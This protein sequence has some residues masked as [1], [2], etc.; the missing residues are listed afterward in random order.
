MPLPVR[1]GEFTVIVVA[2]VL[3]F[4]LHKKYQN[5]LKKAR[6]TSDISM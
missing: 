3:P 2:L 6:K 5:C 1:G 4:F